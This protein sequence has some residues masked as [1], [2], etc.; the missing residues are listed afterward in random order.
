MDP[1]TGAIVAMAN[2]PTYDPNN[3][4]NVYELEKV[5]YSKYPNP[6]FDLLGMPVFV[7]DTKKGDIY[8]HEN[9]KLFL[10]LATESER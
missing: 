2:Y 3:F 8:Y 7:E 1:K 5:S 6:N 10:R 4:G 9:K